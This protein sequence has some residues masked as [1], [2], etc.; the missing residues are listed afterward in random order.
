MI[1]TVALEV[2]RQSVGKRVTSPRRALEGDSKFMK[3]GLDRAADLRGRA[4]R[5]SATR[6][7]AAGVAIPDSRPARR[8]GRSA[9]RATAAADDSL[10]FWASSIAIVSTGGE[11]RLKLGG[12]QA[13]EHASTTRIE[14]LRRSPRRASREPEVVVKSPRTAGK[15]KTRANKGHTPG[16]PRPSG[17]GE[18]R[19]ILADLGLPQTRSLATERRARSETSA[20]A[21]AMF[22]GH[23]DPASAPCSFGGILVE[24]D[25]KHYGPCGSRRDERGTRSRPRPRPDEP[26]DDLVLMNRVSVCTSRF[27]SQTVSAHGAG[28]SPLRP[29][30]AS[31]DSRPPQIVSP[32]ATG[33]VEVIGP[34]GRQAEDPPVQQLLDRAVEGHRGESE[35]R[36]RAWNWPR[37]APREIHQPIRS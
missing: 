31:F 7:G 8:Q 35:H 12:D 28:L 1:R 29:G 30:K 4:L 20:I 37:P 18:L 19:H 21:A 27:R 33:A 25:A 24:V 11:T 32:R 16:R 2:E 14:P 5:H 13:G 23:L 34:W 10:I 17:P 22:C 3:V 26:L 36:S 6:A 9:R 15:Q